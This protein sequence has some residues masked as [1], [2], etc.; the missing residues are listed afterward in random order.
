MGDTCFRCVQLA[1]FLLAICCWPAAAQ[2]PPAVPVQSFLSEGDAAY[3][4]GDYEAARRSFTKAQQAAQQLPSGSPL[5][6]EV[7]RRLASASAASGQFVDAARYLE[8]AAKWRESS[9][10]PKD[11]KIVDDLLLLINLKMRTKEFDQAL[12][13][14]QRVEAMHVEAYTSE[15]IPV[16]DDLLRI[17]QIY[18][19]EEKTREA[20]RALSKAAE[21]RT[22]LVGSLDPGLLPILDNLI[23]A[24]QKLVGGISGGA[25]EP[26]Y[27]EALMIRETVYGKDST[28]LIATLEGLAD[29]YAADGDYRAEP[30]YLR[31]LA[32]WEKAVGKDHPMIAVTLDKLVVLYA[33]QGKSEMARTALARSVAIRARFLAVGLAQQADD[34]ISTSHG[35]EARALYN[36]AL[37]VL[38]PS[39]PA[40][41]ELISQIRE[42]LG[43]LPSAGPK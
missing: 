22:K 14:A 36:R 8:Q 1:A 24:F 9:I 35:E 2:E 18:L 29:T 41:E 16:A 3:A 42:A 40:N 12:V 25:T 32:L 27:R 20:I 28:E 10:G 34:E 11:P 30:T 4:Q 15:S 17:G 21:L 19:A 13:T 43:K 33:K 7:L 31:L 23:E 38:S 5:R 37:A 26:L 39:D 6:Y